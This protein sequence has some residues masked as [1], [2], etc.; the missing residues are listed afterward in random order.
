MTSVNPWPAG[1]RYDSPAIGP[2]TRWALSAGDVGGAG[3][4]VGAALRWAGC[5][6]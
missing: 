5:P 2:V 4:G 6:R 1:F 3:Q